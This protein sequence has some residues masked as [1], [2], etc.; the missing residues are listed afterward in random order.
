MVQTQQGTGVI[1]S[2]SGNAE[3][4]GGAVHYQVYPCSFLDV[5]GDGT[6][7]LAGI[8][9]KLD[10]IRTLGVDGLCICPFFKCREKTSQT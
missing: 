3:W 1:I 2:T 5:D 6:A 4:W 10:Y 9:E 7:D 8:M